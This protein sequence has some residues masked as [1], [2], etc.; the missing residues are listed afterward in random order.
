VKF[1]SILVL[2]LLPMLLASCGSLSA[3][4]SPRIDATPA[5]GMSRAQIRA[6]YGEPDSVDRSGCCEVWT[7]TFN[8]VRVY[9]P[10]K[11]IDRARN[12]VFV[13]GHSGLLKDYGYNE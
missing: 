12:A 7:Y 2:V 1:R 4:N 5:L 6:F 9:V 8:T 10:D 3:S 13:F 11:F